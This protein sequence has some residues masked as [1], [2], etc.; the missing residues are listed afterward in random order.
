M[1]GTRTTTVHGSEWLSANADATLLTEFAHNLAIYIAKLKNSE[2][3]CLGKL[4]TRT[5]VAEVLKRSVFPLP[6]HY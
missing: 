4:F 1:V 6:E 2:A 3:S 5:T